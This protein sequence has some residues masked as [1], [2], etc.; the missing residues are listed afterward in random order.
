MSHS[1]WF[2]ADLSR[3]RDLVS[4]EEEEEEKGV[5]AVTGWAGRTQKTKGSL[6][7]LVQRVEVGR[8]GE[9]GVTVGAKER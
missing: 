4:E 6:F 3:K 9:E 1:I 7:L 2:S 8:R 5:E